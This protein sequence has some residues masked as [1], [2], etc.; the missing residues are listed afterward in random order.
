MGR[1]IQ[2]HRKTIA[3]SKK[4]YSGKYRCC[5]TSLKGKIIILDNDINLQ[6]WRI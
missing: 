6:K 5:K 2:V 3:A 4:L 1:C